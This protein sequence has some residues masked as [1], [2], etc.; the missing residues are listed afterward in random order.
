MRTPID[1]D[2][3]EA[4]AQLGI[5]ALGYAPLRFAPPDKVADLRLALPHLAKEADARG[6]PLP[7]LALRGLLASR[8][9]ISLVVGCGRIETVHE[10]ALVPDEAWD[11]ALDVAFARDRKRFSQPLTS[12]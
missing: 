2:A 6:V 11:D 7:R 9:A 4:C 8:P 1:D 10:I 3:V 12:R 5:A